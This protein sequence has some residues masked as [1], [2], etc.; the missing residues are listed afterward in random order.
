[1]EAQAKMVLA[2]FNPKWR[3]SARAPAHS[4]CI[5][6]KDE[7]AA[8]G[9]G[10]YPALPPGYW[11]KSMISWSLAKGP[12]SS[13]IG[14]A[15]VKRSLEQAFRV[16]EEV[17]DVKFCETTIPSGDIEIRFGDG[18]HWCP[19]C[20]GE[21]GPCDRGQHAGVAFWIWIHQTPTPISHH[22]QVAVREIGHSLGLKYSD[23]PSSAMFPTYHGFKP[24]FKLHQDDIDAIQALYGPP[25]VSN[26]PDGEDFKR[27]SFGH[28]YQDPAT[29]DV[30]QQIVQ[31]AEDQRSLVVCMEE[32]SRAE[33]ETPRVESMKKQ[34]SAAGDKPEKSEPF[35]PA[36]SIDSNLTISKPTTSSLLSSAKSTSASSL[37]PKKP[38]LKQAGPRSNKIN[39]MVK[40]GVQDNQPPVHWEH[41]ELRAKKKFYKWSILAILVLSLSVALFF[42]FFYKK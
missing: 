33:R 35:K 31:A 41:A 36:K 40:L 10:I 30:R 29:K 14:D 22:H 8:G 20:Q 1:V 9:G 5:R 2:C 23:K 4:T 13:Q 24:D 12:S 27:L 38:Q 18:S 42:F 15:E 39:P 34:G 17:A 19:W 3:K 7:E 21:E 28:L 11:D 16:W 37:S 25:R 6:P 26:F 32:P